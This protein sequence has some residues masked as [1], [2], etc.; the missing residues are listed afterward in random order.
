MAVAKGATILD[1]ARSIGVDVPTMCHLNGYEHFT[2]CMVCVVKEK[3]SG[4]LLPSC[5]A[6]A[7]DGMII[8]TDNEETRQARK[9]ALDLLLSE[10]VGDCEGPCR[11][12]CPAHMNIP[13]MIRMIAAGR[14]RDAIEVVKADI[15]LPAVLGRIC[16]APCEKGCR[17]GQHDAPVAICLLKR[18]AA[19]VDLA[20]KSPYLSPCKPATGKKVAV[21]GAG[22]T[23][24]SAAYYLAQAGHSCTVFDDHTEAGGQLR[25]GTEESVLPRA[26]LE[27]EIAIIRKLGVKFLMN[28]MVGRD[29]TFDQLKKE[30]DAVVLSVGKVESKSCEQYGVAAGERGIQVDHRTL[31]TSVEKIFAGG[32]AVQPGHMAVRAVAHGKTMAFAIDQYLG[33]VSVTGPARRFD[34][35]MGRLQENEMKEFLKD[36]DQSA[37]INPVSGPTAGFSEAEA[38]KECGRC[39]HCDCRKADA[40]VLRNLAEKYESGQQ[41]FKVEVRKPFERNTTHPDVLFEPGKCIK[42]GICVRIT[43]RAHE[44]LGLTFMGRG[45]ETVVKAPFNETLGA[46]LKDTAEECVKNCP[47]GALALKDS[48]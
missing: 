47:T 13:L 18:Y 34:S 39:L 41:R 14:M 29:V 32:E 24:L 25:T 1:A 17:R 45:F 28:T 23:G 31:R 46:G 44:K 48:F 7:A 35:R 22:P 43:E 10:H 33:G 6:P 4:R 38:I 37:R 15:A 9:T 26:V 30:Y 5:S 19:D 21:V 36:S 20:G 16:P 27:S 2:S 11:T 40:C 12:V 8:E 3:V 42:C